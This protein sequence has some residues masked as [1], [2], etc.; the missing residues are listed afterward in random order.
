MAINFLDDFPDQLLIKFVDSVLLVRLL[1]G[2]A[3][4]IFQASS[5]CKVIF[6]KQ[7]IFTQCFVFLFLKQYILKKSGG[8]SHL[9]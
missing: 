3:N 6:W 5:V 4:A 9:F 2:L 1:I 7:F 8:A